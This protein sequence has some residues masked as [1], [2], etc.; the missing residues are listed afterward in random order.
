MTTIVKKKSRSDFSPA[1]VL[2]PNEGEEEGKGE[3]SN[4]GS[5]SPGQKSLT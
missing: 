1:T 5:R 3:S 4:F 2:K